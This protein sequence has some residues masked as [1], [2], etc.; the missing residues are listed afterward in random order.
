M[1]QSGIVAAAALYAL[2]HNRER[3]AQDHAAARGFAERL[4]GVPG[5]EVAPV[6]TNIVLLKTHGA[7]ASGIAQRAAEK[8]VLLHAMGPRILRAV[9]HLDIEEQDVLKAGEL[10]A[11]LIAAEKS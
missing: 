9:T 2:D 10:L 1:R 8:G 3:L 11:E 5:I 6:E 4:S 7:D